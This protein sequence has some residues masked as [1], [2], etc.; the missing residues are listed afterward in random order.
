MAQV[1]IKDQGLPRVVE[2]LC[3]IDGVLCEDFSGDRSVFELATEGG[4]RELE[5]VFNS[6][7]YRVQKN[8]YEL[9][10]RALTELGIPEGATYKPP[11][12]PRRGM[13]PHIRATRERQKQVFEA[14]Q[15]AWRTIR[16]A[17]K[18]L[19]VEYE[20]AQMKDYY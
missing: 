9:L 10:C 17:E 2:Q 11:P 5:I 16:K 7:D 20:I 3:S 1:K 14:W 19:D 4:S 8:Q 6:G 12:P 15:E 18:A 13:T